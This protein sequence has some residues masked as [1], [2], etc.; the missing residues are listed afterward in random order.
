ML[1]PL[2]SGFGP[3]QAYCVNCRGADSTTVSSWPSPLS[4]SAEHAVKRTTLDLRLYNKPL[5]SI[6]ERMSFYWDIDSLLEEIRVL[7]EA[8]EFSQRR[9]EEQAGLSCG[10]LSRLLSGSRELKIWQMLA[11]LGVLDCHPVDFFERT[12]PLLNSASAQPRFLDFRSPDETS[13][14]LAVCTGEQHRRDR[15]IDQATKRLRRRGIESLGALRLRLARCEQAVA[16]L[17]GSG[18]PVS[19]SLIRG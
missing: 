9:V 17:E 6:I 14:T 2:A 13:C 11:V 10:Y 4:L 5:V 16:E 8:S 7:V 18:T 15:E 3:R 12:T 1:G 19:V